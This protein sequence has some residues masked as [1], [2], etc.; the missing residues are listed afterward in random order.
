MSDF[1]VTFR[2]FLRRLPYGGI[3]FG[4]GLGI[5]VS[6]VLYKIPI[7]GIF[8][9]GSEWF[10]AM[11]QF[12][13][14]AVTLFFAAYQIN[15]QRLLNTF[16]SIF[17]LREQWKSEEMCYCRKVICENHNPSSFSI[18]ANEGAVLGFFE[19]IGVYLE[20]GVLGE[21]IIWDLY[22]YWIEH[23]WI[24]FEPSIQ[25]YRRNTSDKTYFE[26]FESLYI[27]IAIAN[28]VRT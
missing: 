5:V 8:G 25:E 4:L 12:I 7:Q 24:I 21:K 27:R 20:R 10:W 9:P 11:A 2:V 16:S 17:A 3:A 19:E 23:Y 22:S 15:L 26:H 6:L 18:G 28:L 13:V 14:I 1:L